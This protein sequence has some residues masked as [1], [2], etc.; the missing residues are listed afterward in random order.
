MSTGLPS[1]VIQNA[2]VSAHSR[3]YEFS[4]AKFDQKLNWEKWCLWGV[5]WTKAMTST[6]SLPIL[7][8]GPG[9]YPDLQ[10]LY[11]GTLFCILNTPPL[12][13]PTLRDFINTAG[14]K[15]LLCYFRNMVMIMVLSIV[16]VW[17]LMQEIPFNFKC[18]RK[19]LLTL[20][21]LCVCVLS[22]HHA[23]W[24]SNHWLYFPF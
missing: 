3:E 20:N 23:K 9:V 21:N 17:R 11:F 2:F 8:V 15:L 16:P 13:M 12:H 19:T 14:G 4:V 18:Q 1:T 6:Y 7:A 5:G 22:F 10:N 24:E